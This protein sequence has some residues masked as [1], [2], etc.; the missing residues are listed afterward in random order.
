[1]KMEGIYRVVCGFVLIAAGI[2][3]LVVVEDPI[4]AAMFFGMGMLMFAPLF[5]KEM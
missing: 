4:H 5:R 2:V 1:M 3:Q